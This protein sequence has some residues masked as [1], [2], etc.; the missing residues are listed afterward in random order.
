MGGNLWQRPL[1]VVNTEQLYIRVLEILFVHK[2]DKLLRRN[3]LFLYQQDSE[4]EVY[5]RMPRQ[6]P[7]RYDGG[8]GMIKKF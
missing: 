4:R 5:P 1:L 7:Q 3:K 6:G 2:R 8:G